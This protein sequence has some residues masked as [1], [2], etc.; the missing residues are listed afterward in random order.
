LLYKP[1][2]KSVTEHLIINSVDTF[3][4]LLELS[5]IFKNIKILD[6]YENCY[7]IKVT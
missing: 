7:H 3:G 2:N 4:I 1:N 5:N 6:L